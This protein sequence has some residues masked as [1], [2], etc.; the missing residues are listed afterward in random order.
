MLVMSKGAL[1]VGQA[2][3]YYQEKYSEDDY[4]TES[5][6][7]TGE[8][9]GR[10]AETLG[11]SG[12]VSEEDFRTML[13]GMKPGSGEVLVSAAA[14]RDERRAGWDATFNAPK[15]VS[16]QALVG[17]D[18]RLLEAHRHAVERALSELEKFAQAR[19]HRGQEWVTTSQHRRGPLRPH[20]RAAIR[21]R[22]PGRLR[23][24]PSPPHP[25]RDRQH[26]AAAGR[27]VAGSQIRSRSIAARA[28]RPRFTAR[29]LPARSKR[30]DIESA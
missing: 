16:I 18:A 6:R 24:R 11:L 30:S 9:Y 2:E 29:N 10:A 20:R 22:D 14:G 17:E 1:S 23:P 13:R 28:S 25:R 7:V 8:W 5:H 15:S 3:T 19:R 12:A 27:H 21:D 4:Y 26:D